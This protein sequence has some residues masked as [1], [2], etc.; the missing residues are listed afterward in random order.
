MR[1]LVLNFTGK[2][3]LSKEKNFGQGKVIQKTDKEQ[4]MAF[5][6]LKQH[7]GQDDNPEKI[8]DTWNSKNII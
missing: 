1:A 3:I 4:N 6:E 2:D 7:Q 5:L 8:S